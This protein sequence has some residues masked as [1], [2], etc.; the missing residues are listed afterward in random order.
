MGPGAGK[1]GP[2]VLGPCKWRVAGKRRATLLPG[3]TATSSKAGCGKGPQTCHRTPQPL[4]NPGPQGLRMGPVA[5]LAAMVVCGH[6]RSTSVGERASVQRRAR[7]GDCT[8]RWRVIS[9]NDTAAVPSDGMGSGRPT[10]CVTG[11]RTA[12]GAQE[13]GTRRGS[14]I[15]YPISDGPFSKLKRGKPRQFPRLVTPF[16]CHTAASG[17]RPPISMSSGALA[18]VIGTSWRP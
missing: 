6:L 17:G 4:S 12:T 13:S 3:L 14:G 15:R 7:K 16:S 8:A 18:A 10:G 2:R 11:T 1:L 5:R 9:L